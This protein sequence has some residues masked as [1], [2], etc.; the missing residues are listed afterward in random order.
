MIISDDIQSVNNKFFGGDHPMSNQDIRRTAAG[1]GVKL[2]QIA[3]A[4]GIADCS[5]SRKLRKELPQE[6]KEK[7]FSI[8]RELS[9]EVS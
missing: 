1:A 5:F 3:D 6:E 9:Q 8:I 7:I 4:S 2:W